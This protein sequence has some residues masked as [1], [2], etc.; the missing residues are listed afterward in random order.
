MAMS[1]Y[2][3]LI[4]QYKPFIDSAIGYLSPLN[5]KFFIYSG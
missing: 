1:V 4:C 2:S 3:L 5:R